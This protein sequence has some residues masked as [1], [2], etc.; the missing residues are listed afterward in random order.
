MESDVDLIEKLTGRH[1]PD[2]LSFLSERPTHTAIMSG[3]IQDNGLESNLNRGE[4]Y[5]Y[6][7]A[8]GTLEGVALIGHATLIE[9]K[10]DDAIAAFAR[11]VSQTSC[12]KMI[13]GE[14]DTIEK[15][16]AAY[17][18]RATTEYHSRNEL[19]FEQRWAAAP[20]GLVP[21]LRRA[22]LA[23]LSLVIT[24][25]A[26]M[27]EEELGIN[28]LRIDADGFQMRCERRVRQG[29]VWVLINNGRLIFKADVIS[30]TAAANYI[31]GVYVNPQERSKGYGR[32]C[33]AQV[34]R[35]LLAQ[36]QAVCLLVSEHNN[37]GQGL[38][39]TAGYA[40]ISCYQTIFLRPPNA[41]RFVSKGGD[42]R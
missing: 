24:A 3:L 6:R 39:R 22:T 16:W 10:S 29:R 11:R 23:D 12:V 15:F 21:G 13:L 33:L 20:T 27:A 17:A 38:A 40:V 28:P 18:R 19:M 36:T 35:E 14:R 1:A 25:H 30:A 34:T 7:G 8:A 32:R 31:E 4:F 5:G 26:F 9:T 42:A 41:Y 37:V 2:V